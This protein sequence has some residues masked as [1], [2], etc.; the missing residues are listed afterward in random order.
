M[1]ITRTGKIIG[2]LTL[3]QPLLVVVYHVFIIVNSHWEYRYIIFPKIIG[4]VLRAA[5]NYLQIHLLLYLEEIPNA[6]RELVSWHVRVL[7]LAHQIKHLD[8]SLS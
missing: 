4:C 6:F 8:G 5:V 7:P 3:F 1:K 2:S